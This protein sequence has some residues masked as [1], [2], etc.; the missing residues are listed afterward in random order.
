[1]RKRVNNSATT[2]LAFFLEI[3]G[4]K[5]GLHFGP[6]NEDPAAWLTMGSNKIDYLPMHGQYITYPFGSTL[7]SALRVTTNPSR[8]NKAGALSTIIPVL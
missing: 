3:I 8:I 1:M 5:R 7:T 2:P 4:G 6:R